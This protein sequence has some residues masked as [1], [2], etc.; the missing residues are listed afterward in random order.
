MNIISKNIN[1]YWLSAL[2]L[3]IILATFLLAYWQP[4]LWEKDG[5][6]IIFF[7]VGFYS[8]GIISALWMFQHHTL[9]F[10]KGEYLRSL[11]IC[12][13]ATTVFLWTYK[14][15]ITFRM[16]ILLLLLCFIYGIIHRKWIKPAG[17]IISFFLL[18]IFRFLAVFWNKDQ[19]FAWENMNE[20]MLYLLLIV[21]IICIGFRIKELE[22]LTFITLCFKIFLF[23]L[24]IN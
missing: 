6:K 7:K 24:T 22:T 13:G 17:T 8:C 11:I 14:H 23:L 16:D 4:L 12:V 18:A 5:F 21:P 20:D 2:P 19:T 10:R 1:K 15:K 3:I 9:L